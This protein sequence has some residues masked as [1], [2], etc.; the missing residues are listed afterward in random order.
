MNV[1]NTEHSKYGKDQT[2]VMADKSAVLGTFQVHDDLT[3]AAERVGQHGVELYSFVGRPHATLRREDG[4]VIPLARREAFVLFLHEMFRKASELPHV[5]K[6]SSR[7]KRASTHLDWGGEAFCRKAGDD[8][9]LTEDFDEVDCGWCI[10][11]MDR[12]FEDWTPA[13]EMVGG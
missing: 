11:K 2:T 12:Q 10:Q 9:N 4:V 7:D 5:I 6:T 8:P 1:Q 3:I 13:Q